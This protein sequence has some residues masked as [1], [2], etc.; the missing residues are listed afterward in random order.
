MALPSIL[1]RRAVVLACTLPHR[2]SDW[3]GNAAVDDNDADARRAVC[4]ADTVGLVCGAGPTLEVLLLLL[5]LLVLLL[6]PPLGWGLAIPM[7]A[8]LSAS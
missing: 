7:E 4:N 3:P 1:T 5:P 2:L 8:V 6:F